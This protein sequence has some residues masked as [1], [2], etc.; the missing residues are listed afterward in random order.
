[1][2]LVGINLTSNGNTGVRGATITG[3]NVLLG[4]VVPVQSVGNGTK[5]YQVNSCH[6]KNAMKNQAKLRPLPNTWMDNYASY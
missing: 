6:V 4:D 3:L 2:V 5:T 1:V